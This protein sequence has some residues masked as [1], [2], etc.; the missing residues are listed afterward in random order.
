MI[1][2]SEK[3]RFLWGG[4][5]R[6][7]LDLQEVHP[8]PPLE[9]HKAPPE[10]TSLP[11]TESQEL[12]VPSPILRCP[13][14][15]REDTLLRRPALGRVDWVRHPWAEV[16]AGFPVRVEA[17]IEEQRGFKAFP[18]S[19]LDPGQAAALANLWKNAV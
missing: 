14:R 4:G 12:S 8:F 18:L 15:T 13:G 9:K 19:P 1:W 16:L 7:R 10:Q 11:L 2:G 5:C 3:N 6:E 17:V